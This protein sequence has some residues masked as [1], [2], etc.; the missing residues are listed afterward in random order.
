MRRELTARGWRHAAQSHLV[1]S[2]RERN[3]YNSLVKAGVFCLPFGPGAGGHAH[4]HRW[5]NIVDIKRRHVLIE[6]GRFPV[7]VISRLT[8][9]HKSEAAITAGLESGR[10][11][12]AAIEAPGFAAAARPL[13]DNWVSAGLGQYDAGAFRTT[14]A[15]AFWITNL[16]GGLHAVLASL[17]TA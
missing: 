2:P 7:E 12:L 5:R 4:G 6:E 10:L 8:S 1:R 13:I 9:R 14:P 3:R 11:D 16:T 17:P 15:G